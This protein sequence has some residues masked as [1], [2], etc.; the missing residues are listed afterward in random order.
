MK[1]NNDILSEQKPQRIGLKRTDTHNRPVSMWIKND[2][3]VQ[4]IMKKKKF[5]KT[6]TSFKK[7]YIEKNK[8]HEV[9]ALE[10]NIRRLAKEH[11]SLEFRRGRV[12]TKDSA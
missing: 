7:V 1:L 2:L 5:L 12:V 4:E 6:S 9:Q 10:A 3:D 11:P 8:P